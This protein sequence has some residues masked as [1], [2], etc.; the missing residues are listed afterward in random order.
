MENQTK[1]SADAASPGP[2]ENEKQWK[3]WEDFF[4][5]YARSHIGAN[6]VPLS[7]VIRE[8]EKP[9]I[10]GEHPNFINK[11][12]ACAPLEGE[13]YA[14]DRMYVFN[15]VVSFTT[16][17]PSGDWIKTTMKKSDGRRSMEALCRHFAGEDNATRNLAESKRLNES[18]HYKSKREIS[19]EIFLTQSQKFFN[20]Y[21]KEGEEMSNEA[22]VR[23]L[24]RKV[25]HAGPHSSIDD[26]KSLQTTG[27][28][29]SYNMAANHLSTATSELP[30]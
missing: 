9:D 15:M 20:I 14:A 3:H 27:T 10:N 4:S 13:Y 26:L 5:N 22:K 16:G 1:S 8:N 19:F 7:Y 2:L 12:V 25:Q 24:F 11:T 30:E 17:P 28:T 23:F 21:K 29:I 6:G 18:I